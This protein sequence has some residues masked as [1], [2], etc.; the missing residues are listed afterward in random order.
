MMMPGYF[1]KLKFRG[2]TYADYTIYTIE[3]D[4]PEVLSQFI[5][6]LVTPIDRQV[7][8]YEKKVIHDEVSYRSIHKQIIEKV[9]KYFRGQSY[10]YTRMTRSTLD[11]I[12]EYHQKYYTIQNIKILTEHIQKKDIEIVN[13]SNIHTLSIDVWA[14]KYS[15]H[16]AEIT[17]VNIFLFTHLEKIYDS[18]LDMIGRYRDGIYYTEDTMQWEHNWFTW[19]VYEKYL[20]KTIGLI[21]ETFFHE[22]FSY[23]KFSSHSEIMEKN[24]D[25]DLICLLNFWCILSDSTKQEILAKMHMFYREIQASEY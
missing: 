5:E 11:S 24:R 22:Y 7:Y 15:G 8:F 6:L 10:K 19:L 12:N 2:N 14:K 1:E 16:Y 4:N 21:P 13:L 18:Y 23:I 17:P 20:S 25:I 9:G 3:S